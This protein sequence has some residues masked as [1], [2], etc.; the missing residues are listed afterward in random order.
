M[1]PF[2]DLS[3]IS[4]EL[5]KGRRHVIKLL[6]LTRPARSAD[7]LTYYTAIADEFAYRHGAKLVGPVDL[8]PLPFR[9]SAELAFT[10][11]AYKHPEKHTRTLNLPTTPSGRNTGSRGAPGSTASQ[12]AN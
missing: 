4:A 11:R 5:I 6:V 9:E 8:S 2:R 1:L 3:I 12:P 7:Y 10:V